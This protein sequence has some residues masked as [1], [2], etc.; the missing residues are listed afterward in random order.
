ML[1]SWAWADFVALFISCETLLANDWKLE[2][3]LLRLAFA[4]S[5][6][7]LEID[8]KLFRADS[9]VPFEKSGSPG[10]LGKDDL[11]TRTVLKD[12]CMGMIHEYRLNIRLLGSKRL[13]IPGIDGTPGKLLNG[14]DEFDLGKLGKLGKPGICGRE[15]K[16]EED[17]FDPCC[18]K[19]GICG[20]P[21][22]EGSEPND[23]DELPSC[24]GRPGNWG[25]PGNFGFNKFERPDKMKTL[26]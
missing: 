15:F 24:C 4:C 25:S 3:A 21:G 14:E 8:W 5:S 19:P 17:W 1:L 20:K 10:K 9:T 23:D 6:A 16:R 2:R 7:A 12:Y 18:G 13:G 11:A 26:Q 22:N